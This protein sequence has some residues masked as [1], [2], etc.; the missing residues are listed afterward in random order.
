MPIVK[1][2]ANLNQN[3]LSIPKS[4][5]ESETLCKAYRHAIFRKIE[6]KQSILSQ[7]IFVTGLY[8]S[9]AKTPN[10]NSVH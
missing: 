3:K 5:S 4:D 1:K 7:Q 10:A 8:Q 9:W 2:K 6:K